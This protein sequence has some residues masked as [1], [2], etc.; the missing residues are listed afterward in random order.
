MCHNYTHINLYF[1][2]LSNKLGNFKIIFNQK[3]KAK[4][5]IG[6]YVNKSEFDTLHSRNVC[7]FLIEICSVKLESNF[8]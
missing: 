4:L 2:I 3:F 1:G 5:V 6:N 8:G 7:V